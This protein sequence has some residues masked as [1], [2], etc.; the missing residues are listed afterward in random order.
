VETLGYGAHLIIDGFLAEPAHLADAGRAETLLRDLAG[1]L[2]PKGKPL[3]TFHPD[4]GGLSGAAL[5]AEAH[6]SIHTF[7]DL[8]ALTLSVFS[9]R[10]LDPKVVTERLEAHY[11]LRRFESHLKNHGRTM[12]KDEEQRR[13]TLRGDRQYA[14]ARLKDQTAL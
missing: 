13:R 12:A 10:G 11:G 6:L 8:G 1:L 3:L 2:E 4:D 7:A 9:R 14:R 5:L